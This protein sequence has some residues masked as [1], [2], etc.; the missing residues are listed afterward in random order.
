M[1]KISL[2]ILLDV[3]FYGTASWFLAVGVLRYLRADSRICFLAATLIAAA[4]GLCVYAF[5]SARLKRRALNRKE[6]EQRNAILLHLALE[7]GER[8]RAAL[9]EAFVA[10]GKD[11]HCRGDALCVDGTDVVP[12]FTMQPVSADAVAALL[13]DRRERPFAVACNDLSPEAET[14]LASFGK[15]TM[16]GDEICALFERTDTVPT[17]LIC[18]ELPRKN[19]RKK[20]RAAFSKQ[21]ARPFFVSGIALLVMS[22]FVF[23]PVYYLI[24]GSILLSAA[25]VVRAFGHT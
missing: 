25:I 17:P 14:L 11:A 13:K 12:L 22:L 18:G 1:R 10:D 23:Y 3:L 19:V 24:T 6:R 16:K 20:L 15:E 2:P 9:L 21:N 7:T 8:V 4:S 5:S